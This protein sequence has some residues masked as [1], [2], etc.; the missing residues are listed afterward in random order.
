M[1]GGNHVSLQ[2][3][4]PGQG[5]CEGQAGRHEVSSRAAPRACKRGRRGPGCGPT[6]RIR[7]LRYERRVAAPGASR[8]LCST[9]RFRCSGS[10]PCSALLCYAPL[11]ND[12][13]VAVLSCPVC[14]LS[15][16]CLAA[17]SICFCSS[18]PALLAAFVVPVCL[19]VEQAARKSKDY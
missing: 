13:A 15:S 18:P 4:H 19:R 17:G 10:A 6:E 16:L 8:S 5:G 14:R 3:A 12:G 11:G 1:I 7:V 2:Q 9:R